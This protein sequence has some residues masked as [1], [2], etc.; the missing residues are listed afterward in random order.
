VGVERGIA[1]V[2]W[3]Y[4]QGAATPAATVVKLADLP[5]ALPAETARITPAERKAEIARR[6]RAIARRWNF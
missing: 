2:R 5:A 3:Y 6:A 1:L 4:A